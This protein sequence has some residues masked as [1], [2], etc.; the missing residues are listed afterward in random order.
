LK[1]PP[2]TPITV[3]TTDQ[4]GLTYDENVTFR[5]RNVNETPTALTL[6]GSTTGA[7]SSAVYNATTDSYYTLVSTSMT[8]EAAMDNAQA[9]FLGGVAGTLMQY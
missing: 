3:R 6:T 8:W 4:V 7:G 5:L 1:P 2:T 9:S